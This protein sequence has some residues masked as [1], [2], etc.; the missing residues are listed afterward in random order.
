MSADNWYL[1]VT[2]DNID[3]Y[4][5][6]TEEEW[7]TCIDY[8]SYAL[9]LML[10]DFKKE[11][12]KPTIYSRF[13]GHRFYPDAMVFLEMVSDTNVYIV[14]NLR[15]SLKAEIID[16]TARTRIQLSYFMML[17]AR[18]TVRTVYGEDKVLT[19]EETQAIQRIAHRAKDHMVDANK[20][21]V[22]A[23]TKKL[24]DEK[25]PEIYEFDGIVNG[26]KNLFWGL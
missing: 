1:D 16:M 7:K 20:L 13:R 18:N 14:R 17:T 9:A 19:L 26:E 4:K 21:A 12:G 11:I 22:S 3:Q 2:L 8:R 5:D 25:I 24:W 15:A 10:V 23:D 6:T